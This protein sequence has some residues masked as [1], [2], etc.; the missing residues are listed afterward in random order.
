LKRVFKFDNRLSQ[1]RVIYR[2]LLDLTPG[3]MVVTD[4][5]FRGSPVV[6]QSRLNRLSQIEK[7]VWKVRV[8]EEER[9]H[10]SS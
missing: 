1:V 10:V 6:R 3:G 8:V 5:D 2:I 9:E 4:A 7:D